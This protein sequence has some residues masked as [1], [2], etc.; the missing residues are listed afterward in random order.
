VL[1]TTNPPLGF[2][3][4]KSFRPADVRARTRTFD[5]ENDRLKGK[6]TISGKKRRGKENAKKRMGPTLD[7]DAHIFQAAS[8]FWTQNGAL[9]AALTAR[10]PCAGRW[11]RK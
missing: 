11:G 6:K 1:E 5:R 8:S 7:A 10:R 9:D 4:K 3:G 2:S